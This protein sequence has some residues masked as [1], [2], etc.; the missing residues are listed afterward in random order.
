MSPNPT[1]GGINIKINKKEKDTL[2]NYFLYDLYGTTYSM[3]SHYMKKMKYLL[4]FSLLFFLSSFSWAQNFSF[5]FNTN[6]KR[7]CLVESTIDQ[8]A[9]Q[10]TINF[11]DASQNTTKPTSVYRRPMNGNGSDWVLQVS[12][13]LPGTSSWTD[14][15]VSNG[16][17]WEYLVKRT[18]TWTYQGVNYDATGYTAASILF[19]QSNYRGQMIL[20]IADN[21]NSGLKEKIDT[22]KSDLTGEGWHVNILVV[23]AA[24]GWESGDTVVMVKNQI[25]SLYNSLPVNDKPKMLFILGHVPLPRSG[26]TNVTAP[27]GHDQ[28]K[29]ARGAD[30]YY[31][32]MDGVFTDTA[33]FNPGGLATPLA[34]NLPG[35]SKWDQDFFPSDVELA[36]GRVD[37]RD[38]TD[39]TTPEV[40]LTGQYLDRLHKYRFI[41]PGWFMGNRTA[42][43][44][45]Y[46]N[47]NDGTYRSLPDI[48]GADSLIEN[49]SGAPHP[50]WVQNNGPFMMYMQNIS[51]PLIAEWNTYGMNASFFSSDQSYWGFGDV[52][53]QTQYSRIRALLAANTKCLVILWTTTGVDLFHQIGTGESMGMACKE[54]M[55]HNSINNKLEKPPQTYDTQA[56]WNRTHFEF[57]G[58]PTLRLYQVYPPQNPVIAN[59]PAG[60]LLNWT[61]SQDPRLTGYHVYKS[62][63]IS[64]IYVKITD[65]NPV[66]TTS[67][68]DSSYQAGNWY[69][70]RAVITQ[71]S[72]SGKFI[73]PSQGVFINQTIT[74]NLQPR[75]TAICLNG[76]ATFSFI[77]SG[78]QPI[79]YQW[80]HGANLIPNATQ[81]A[82]TINYALLSDSETYYCI[83]ANPSGSYQSNNALLTIEVVPPPAINGPGMVDENSVHTYFVTATTSSTFAF[84]VLNGVILNTYP[85]SII[86][87]WGQL[88]EGKVICTETNGIGCISLPS[89]LDVTIG[90]VGTDEKDQFGISIYPNPSTGIIFVTSSRPMSTLLL[91]T[92]GGELFLS[93]KLNTTQTLIDL[94][95][96]SKGIYYLKV[97][98][99]K[100]VVI[101]KVMIY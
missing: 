83:A 101:K 42:F 51:Q 24:K 45:G 21:I 91:Y 28:N 78:V 38:I 53:Q 86:V 95:S 85:D 98:F 30:C 87:Q 57:W 93:K 75:D 40:I 39:Y 9:T 46:D 92:A 73:N 17:I 43:Y 7:V 100:G 29:G 89:A 2:V 60:A 14:Y 36:F 50:Q 99:D 67:F 35:D 41:Y 66:T 11:L 81:S 62:D 88:G 34:V 22:L 82:Y 47:S 32:D 3:N 5:D 49:M 13:L 37:F 76:N 4:T 96:C 68:F 25:L 48:S 74:V 61:A 16:L 26:S 69:M 94:S 64:G 19:D 23:P 80:Y 15:N 72:G 10:V 65:A 8:Q 59:Y 55:N 84:S 56:W 58:D 33:T 63:S 54:I 6:G 71:P 27:D 44:S 97:I 90:S 79:S 1:L 52:P 31:A 18:G 20:L 77:V 12:N 70:I